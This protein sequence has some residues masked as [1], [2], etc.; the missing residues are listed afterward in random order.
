MNRLIE[1]LNFK[2]IAIIYIVLLILVV[3]LLGVFLGNKYKDKINILMSYHSLSE[4]F[5]KDYN[6]DN[7][8][9]S[10]KKLGNISNDIVDVVL[11]DKGGIN[12]SINSF[13]TNDLE[14]INNTNNYYK[15]SNNN[16]YLLEDNEAF[17]KDLFNIKEYNKNDYYNDFLINTDKSRLFTITYLN[18]KELNEK[19]IV[20]SKITNVKDGEYYLKIS[21]SILMLF[22][23]LYWVMVALMIYQNAR[24]LKLN[25]YFWGIVTLFTNIFGVLAYIIYNKK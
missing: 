1:N 13:Y 21:A 3:S 23:M 18:N 17:I 10:M 8:M 19:L 20:I 11:V 24:K 4:I 12:Y 2:K 7:L 22:F 15:D 25:A 16:I 9:S 6:K 5:E 14:S